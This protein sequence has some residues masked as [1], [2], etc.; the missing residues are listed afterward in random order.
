MTFNARTVYA[1][2]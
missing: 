1:I 2:V